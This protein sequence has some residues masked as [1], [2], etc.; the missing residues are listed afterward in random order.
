MYG[1][2]TEIEPAMQVQ[3]QGGR[4]ILILKVDMF[5]IFLIKHLWKISLFLSLSLSL[6]LSLCLSFSFTYA[7][8]APCNQLIQTQPPFKHPLQVVLNPESTPVALVELT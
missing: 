6:Y 1:T 5:E 2:L 4:G 3:S 8:L 7:L